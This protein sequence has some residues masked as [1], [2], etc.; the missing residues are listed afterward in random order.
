M[1]KNRLVITLLT[2]LFS[3]CCSTSLL[4]Q[5][6]ILK[7]DMKDGSVKYIEVNNIQDIT[8]QQTEHE[9]PELLKGLTGNWRLIASNEGKEIAPGVYAAGTDTIYFTAT[10]N[11]NGSSLNCHSDR[12]HWRTPTLY[13]ADWRIVVEQKDG[14]RRIGWVL[15]S[16]N[17]V[18]T[19]GNTNLYLLS[20]NSDATAWLGMTFW[21]SWST[22]S[23]TVY[24][25][26]NEEYNSRKVY[27]LLS[28]SIPFSTPTGMI[29]IWSSPRFE[30]LP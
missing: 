1:N 22:A 21:S 26:S 13:T 25:L 19:K 12:L 10:P 11:V 18:F 7:I 16:E 14:K 27:G 9:T 2:L 20:E 29:E 5:R 23:A 8:I 30:K 3:F 6:N 24:S 4:A 17:P 15:D 28:S